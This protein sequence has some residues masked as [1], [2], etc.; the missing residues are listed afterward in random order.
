M[1]RI[2][3]DQLGENVAIAIDAL[4]VSKLRSAL[5]ILGVVIGVATVM[6]MATIVK[7]IR[8]QI[9]TTISVAGPTTF[10]VMKV[11]SQTPLNPEDLPRWVR[12]RPDLQPSEAE[13]IQM[14]PEVKY[15]S[16]WGQVFGRVE[17]DGTRTQPG[18]I[19]PGPGHRVLSGDTAEKRDRGARYFAAWRSD[20]R[21]GAGDRQALRARRRRR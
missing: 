18:G 4:R 10:Y 3:F 2:S 15:A 6:T 17:Y 14:L 1:R 21:R 11:F 9:L 5:T 13:R 7:G 12:I 20:R 8:D 16:M 19:S